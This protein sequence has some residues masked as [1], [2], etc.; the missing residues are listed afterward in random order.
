MDRYRLVRDVYRRILRDIEA[1]KKLSDQP[2]CEDAA[3]L[4][5][6]AKTMIEEFLNEYSNGRTLTTLAVEETSDDSAIPPR[7]PGYTEQSP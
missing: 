5:Y 4:L 7:F 3:I 2:L 1:L 6:E